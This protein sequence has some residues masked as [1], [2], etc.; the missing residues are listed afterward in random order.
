MNHVGLTVPD[1][2]KALDW[3]VQVLGFT[4]VMGPRIISNSDRN[5]TRA[6]VIMGPR[7]R[8]AYQVQLMTANGVGLE[9][10]QY[11]EP[12]VQRYEP[13]LNMQY[14]R[15]GY[16]HLCYTDPAIEALTAHIVAT[17]GKQRTQIFDMVPGQP[18]KLVYCEDPFGNVIELCSHS[19][20]EVWSNWPQ[21]GMDWDIPVLRRDGTEGPM[22][23][24]FHASVR[25]GTRS[26]PKG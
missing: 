3:Y 23:P 6:A 20:A 10:F 17:G 2:Y 21:I 16:W 7:F 22:T 19:H 1:I 9:L 14:W 8:K 15:Q 26:P 25:E 11:V 24:D 12:E 5:D 4:H 13:D 18:Y